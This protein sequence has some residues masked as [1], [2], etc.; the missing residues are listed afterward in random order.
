MTGDATVNRDAPVICC[1]AEILSNLALREGEH[2][3]VD[4]VVMDE[5]HYYAD[6]DRGWAW[7]V[8]LITLPHTQFLLMSATLGDMTSIMDQMRERSG[9]QAALVQSDD[10]PVP[11][12]FTYR[13]TPLHETIEDLAGDAKAPIYLVNFTQRECAET[14]QKLTSMPLTTKEE[15][16]AIQEAMAGQR[17]TTPYGKE[18][19]RFLGFGIGVHHAGLLPKYR[20]Q[21]EQLAQAGLD[22]GQ[23]L[24]D[25]CRVDQPTD[26]LRYS[27]R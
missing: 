21:V 1:T 26:P 11:L 7:Q 25:E 2:A 27:S 16:K 9:R 6:R 24:F 15:K 14:A 20:L 18:F 19:K 13:E 12:D 8:P 10:R 4:G 5:F 17:F 23:L 22:E 3:E